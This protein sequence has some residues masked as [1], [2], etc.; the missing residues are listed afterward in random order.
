MDFNSTQ[1]LNSP[2]FTIFLQEIV[3]VLLIIF[4]DDLK[5]IIERRNT[6]IPESF[7]HGLKSLLI[8]VMPTIALFHAFIESHLEIYYAVLVF[9]I[10]FV[11]VYVYLRLKYEEIPRIISIVFMSLILFLVIMYSFTYYLFG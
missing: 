1:F 2:T 6:S 10:A 3:V 4:L 11:L 9:V 5:R 8:T 7:I